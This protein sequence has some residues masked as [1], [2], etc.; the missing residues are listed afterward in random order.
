M[1]SPLKCFARVIERLLLPEAVIRSYHDLAL[2]IGI[3]VTDQND[4]AGR[5]DLRAHIWDYL[6][7]S[8]SE[9]NIT[10]WSEL[11]LWLDEQQKWIDFSRFSFSEKDIQDIPKVPGVYKMKDENGV[12]FYVGKSRNLFQR[13]RSYFVERQK[14][15]EKTLRLLDRLKYF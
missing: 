6:L 13:I 12:V 11:Q 9:I 10:S 3:T 14:P 15:D 2:S 7:D 1:I 4:I 5:L 8:L